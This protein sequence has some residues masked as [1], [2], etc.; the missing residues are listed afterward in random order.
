V[1]CLT[2]ALSS[3][4][5]FP[6][7]D[8]IRYVGMCIVRCRAFQCSLDHAKKLFYRAVNAIFARISRVASEKV[9]LQLIKSKCLP[10]LLYSLEACHLNKSDLLSLDFVIIDF[11]EVI[12]D[13]KYRCRYT[14]ARKFW[15]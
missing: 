14:I 5:V 10:V 1:V 15:F 2:V 6:W 9:T 3:G 13:Q 8:E 11:Y 7:V 4:A 12:H